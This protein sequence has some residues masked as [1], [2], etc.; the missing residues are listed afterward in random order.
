M[1]H[2]KS[3]RKERNFVQLKLAVSIRGSQFETKALAC[4]HMRSKIGASYFKVPGATDNTSQT[5]TIQYR[6]KNVSHKSTAAG[7]ALTCYRLTTARFGRYC[8]VYQCRLR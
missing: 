7:A 1:V 8:W 6:P 3:L 5:E 2:N 4:V